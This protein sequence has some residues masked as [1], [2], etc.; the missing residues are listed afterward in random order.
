M[1]RWFSQPRPNEFRRLFRSDRK[2]GSGRG[3]QCC[4]KIKKNRK[5]FVML[6]YIFNGFFPRVLW[7]QSMSNPPPFL[8]RLLA[9]T[10]TTHRHTDTKN[11]SLL[12]SFWISAVK[13][14]FRGRM[15][16]V[17]PSFFL[18]SF[19]LFLCIYILYFFFYS[20]TVE[21]MFSH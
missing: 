5:I 4:Q 2:I 19:Y 15:D 18:F 20:Q 6:V 9:T 14:S 12:M 1:S 16:H 8:F 11:S 10:T 21:V 7:G 3:A 13:R 17:L